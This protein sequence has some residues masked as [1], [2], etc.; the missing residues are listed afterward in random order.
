M[1]ERRQSERLVL[2][3]KLSINHEDGRYICEGY[4]INISKGGIAFYAQ[5]PFEINMSL[6]LIVYFRQGEKEL[7][8]EV[9]GKVRWIKP[10]GQLY[11]TGVQFVNFTRSTNPKV[12]AYLQMLYSLETPFSHYG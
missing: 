11:A 5:K 6:S 9:K 3:S 7:E 8:E 4:T 12:W 2:Q 10:V 1:E